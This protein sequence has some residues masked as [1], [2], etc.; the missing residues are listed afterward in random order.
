MISALVASS[1][2]PA[3]PPLGADLESVG[4]RVVGEVEPGTL[5]QAVIR[6]APD[7]VICLETHPGD[8]LFASTKALAAASALPVIVFTTDPDAARIEQAMHSGVHAYVINGYALQR[9]RSVVQVAQARFRHE[10]SLR[11]QLADLHHRFDERKLVDRAKGILMRARQ[12]SEDDAFRLLRSAAMHSKQRV[13][14]VSRQVIDSAHY[15]E[16]VNRAGQLRMLSQRLVLLYALRCAEVLPETT[17][18]WFD[19]AFRRTEDNL[20][21]LQRS[22]S[23]PTFGDLLEGVMAPWQRLKEELQRAPQ[24]RRLADIDALAEA[25]LAQAELLT[26]T[27]ESAGLAATLRVINVAGRQRML[28][29]RLAKQTLVAAQLGAPDPESAE[30]AV[31]ATRASFLEGLDFL[32]AI[33]LSTRDIRAELDAA[34]AA[35][36]GLEVALARCRT[37]A[38]RVEVAQTSELLLGQFDRL[39]DH[40]ERSMQTLMG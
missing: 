36:R 20:A 22:V 37:A 40:Y 11:D 39:T 16:A 1:G 4:I 15:A 30:R 3:D 33:P 24:L 27:L 13:G 18:A 35:W 23:M 19:A 31:A 5:V 17:S 2:R 9:L 29:Q 14:Q 7:V 6:H 8:A 10:Q 32:Q 12:I 28:A 25:L 26:A 38:G 34:A 21:T